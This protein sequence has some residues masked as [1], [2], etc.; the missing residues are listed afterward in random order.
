MYIYI[1]IYIYILD[2]MDKFA[3][4]LHQTL[5]YRGWLNLIKKREK[6]KLGSM[7]AGCRI[8]HSHLNNGLG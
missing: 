8:S 5:N 2:E 1:Y 3:Q 6:L 7:H 4:S